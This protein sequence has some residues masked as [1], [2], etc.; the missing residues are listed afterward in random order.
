[1]APRGSCPSHDVSS[2]GERRA[3]KTSATAADASALLP[4]AAISKVRVGVNGELVGPAAAP[5]AAV[6]ATAA[7]AALV[8]ARVA[9]AAAEMA[10]LAGGPKPCNWR[11]L[12]LMDAV[13]C[14]SRSSGPEAASCAHWVS[15][16]MLKVAQAPL[17]DDP[18]G[19]GTSCGPKKAGSGPTLSLGRHTYDSCEAHL[20]EERQ[21]LGGLK[22]HH[23]VANAAKEQ[24]V[25]CLELFCARVAQME[26]QRKLA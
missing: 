8:A 5:A 16:L 2:F 22:F 18:A 21:Q 12:L 1:M 11:C 7:A 3:T 26:L 15:A 20:G 4:P 6:A 17:A 13:Q 24:L 25:L 23:L 19:R 14:C 9:A 10:S